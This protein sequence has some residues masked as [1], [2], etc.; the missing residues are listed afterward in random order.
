MGLILGG[1]IFILTFVL[2]KFSKLPAPPPPF[3]NPAYATAPESN[4]WGGCRCRSY[5]NY[6]GDTLKLLRGYTPPSLPGFNTPARK[7]YIQFCESTDILPF[8]NG[9]TSPAGV[10]KWPFLENEQLNKMLIETAMW[11]L[12]WEEQSGMLITPLNKSEALENH[13]NEKW[14]FQNH[15]K[16]EHPIITLTVISTHRSPF[17]IRWVGGFYIGPRVAWGLKKNFVKLI[18]LKR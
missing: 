16:R 10:A 18:F 12:S 2:L 1:K 4:Y 5:L 15:F 11:L 9:N 7:C 17:T 13:G 6:W 8:L 3:Q 14:L